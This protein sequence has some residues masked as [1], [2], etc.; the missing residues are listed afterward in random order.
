MKKILLYIP[1]ILL[2][3]LSSCKKEDASKDVNASISKLVYFNEIFKEFY[4]DGNISTEATGEEK[5]EYAKLKKI[6]GEY[7]DLM[8][9]INNQVKKEKEALADG[10]EI[11]NYEDAYK[12][13]LKDNEDKINKVT[14]E[15]QKNIEILETFAPKE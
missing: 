13:A 15:F 7:Y 5:S 8:N 4:S 2:I 1:I 3:S 10:D 9:K 6:G 11:D 12:K 14:E